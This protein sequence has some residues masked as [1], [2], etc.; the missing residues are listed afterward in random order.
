MKVSLLNIPEFKEGYFEIQDEAS[1]LV[2]L[3]VKCEVIYKKKP[4]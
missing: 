3:R 1:Q 2:A 4:L